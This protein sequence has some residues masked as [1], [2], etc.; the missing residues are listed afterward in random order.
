[1]SK[2]IPRQA[3]DLTEDW[4]RSLRFSIVNFYLRVQ[5]VGVDE[6]SGQYLIV[7]FLIFGLGSI[8]LARTGSTEPREFIP[9]YQRLGV[10]LG[11]V[12]AVLCSALRWHSFFCL[13]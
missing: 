2:T 13:I 9:G 12:V 7:P 3:L 10:V 6:A 4:S 5:G 8:G 1:M 11:F